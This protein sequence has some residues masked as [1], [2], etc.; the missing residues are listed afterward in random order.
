MKVSRSSGERVR[1]TGD[2]HIGARRPAAEPEELP[3]M[4]HSPRTPDGE[5]H[6]K[7]R[8]RADVQVEPDGNTIAKRR[9]RIA[10]KDADAGI[11]GEVVGKRRDVQVE[12]ESTRTCQ[13][14]S[15]EGE[16]RN[17]GT[18]SSMRDEENRQRISTNIDS[19]PGVPP[20]P[21]PP[22][23]DEPAQGRNKHLSV[24]PEREKRAA[25]SCNVGPTSTGHAG[26]T[27]G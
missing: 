6:D 8:H 23:P 25:A 15:I 17:Q 14:A 24:E 26:S 16:R 13:R 20:E 27:R 7:S 21:P 1:G 10:H 11:D 9:E 5:A 18:P 19:I 2:S 22:M 3:D 4:V 12:V